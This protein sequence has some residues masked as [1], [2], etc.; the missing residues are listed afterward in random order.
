M[1][2]RVLVAYASKSGTTAE[3]AEAIAEALRAQKLSVDTLPVDSVAGLS[4]YSAVVLGSGVR[5][6]KWLPQALAFARKHQSALATLPVAI[7]TVHMLAVG[8][9]EE[10][11]QHREAYTAAVRDI[12]RPRAEAFFA[13]RIEM[14]R[15]S[16]VERLMT[17]AVK[18]P[19]ADD[20]DWTAIRQWSEGLP[21]KLGLR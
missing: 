14:S 19:E 21:E 11:R 9:D 16:L 18:A 4:E 5:I 12:V 17:K 10:S 2:G 15:L 20:R 1:A 13:G 3:V 7:F 6:G 8:A